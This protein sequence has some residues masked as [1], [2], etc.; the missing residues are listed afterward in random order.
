MNVKTYKDLSLEQ[1]LEYM[2]WWSFLEDYVNNALTQIERW[3]GSKQ[4]WDLEMFF[5][6]VSCIDDAVQR[7]RNFLN[8]GNGF[9]NE[10]E[11]DNVFKEFRK[12]I[13]YYK[14]KDIRNDL[15][16]REQVFKQKDSKGKLLPKKSILILGGYNFTTDEYEFNIYKIKLSVIFSVIKIL[17][18]DIKTILNEKLQ[19]F[20]KVKEVNDYKSMIPFNILRGFGETKSNNRVIL[21]QIKLKK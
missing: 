20:Y 1:E 2:L 15:I 5:V 7:I 3:D 9:V 17:K 11:L 16:H 13:K 8:L 6:A 10:S 4:N 18:K 19:V 14:I 21:K 12:K